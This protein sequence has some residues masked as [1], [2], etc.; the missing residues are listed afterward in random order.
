MRNSRR[1]A[2][3]ASRFIEEDLRVLM[4]AKLKSITSKDALERSN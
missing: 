1:D 3:R 4:K 2:R